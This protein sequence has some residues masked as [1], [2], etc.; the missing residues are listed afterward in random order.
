MGEKGDRQGLGV[1]LEE[2]Q[3]E[4]GAAEERKQD[5]SQC[6]PALPLRQAVS[7]NLMCDDFTLHGNLVT[8]GEEP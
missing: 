8:E 6:L 7:E 3:R 1:G 2:S 5:D 4:E